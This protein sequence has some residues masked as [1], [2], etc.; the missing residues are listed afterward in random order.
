MKKIFLFLLSLTGLVNADLSVEQIQKMVMQIHEK[1]EG[2]KLVTLE[3]TKDPFIRISEEDN[4]TTL[5][6]PEKEE[7]KLV[8]HAIVNGKAYINDSWSSLGDNIMGY[9]V[10]YIGQRGVVLRNGNHVKKLFLHEKRDS[11]IKLEERL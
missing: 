8:L 1:R 3:T 10:K 5:V 11:F 4:V 2:V 9:T 6:I 7:A